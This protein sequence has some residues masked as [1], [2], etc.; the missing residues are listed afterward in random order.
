MKLEQAYYKLLQLTTSIWFRG[1]LTFSIKGYIG[2]RKHVRGPDIQ[3][4][5]AGHTSFMIS[6]LKYNFILP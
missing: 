5:G 6:V 2:D 1:G 4:S 3:V